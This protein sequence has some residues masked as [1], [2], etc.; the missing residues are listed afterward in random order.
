MQNWRHLVNTVERM[1]AAVMSG[2]A[3]RRGD[4]ACSQITSGILVTFVKNS[5]RLL[6]SDFTV[7][8]AP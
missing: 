8:M 4:A 1:Y 6:L 2:S 5:G 7:I 3:T